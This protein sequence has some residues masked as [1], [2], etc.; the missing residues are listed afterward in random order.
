MSRWVNYYTDKD[1]FVK[2]E[3]KWVKLHCNT[4][5][6]ENVVD[7]KTRYTADYFVRQLLCVKALLLYSP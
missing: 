1:R 7:H 5:L 6:E 3:L 4:E 2:C